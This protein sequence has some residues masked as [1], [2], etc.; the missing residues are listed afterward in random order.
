[1]V[2]DEPTADLDPE[3]AELVRDAVAEHCADRTVLLIT[4]SSGLVRQADRV[5]SLEGGRAVSVPVPVAA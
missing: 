1:V 3:H 5:V 4:H 2:F